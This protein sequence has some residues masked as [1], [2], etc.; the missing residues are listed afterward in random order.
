MPSGARPGL[1]V[2]IIGCKDLFLNTRV[3]RQAESLAQ[4]G[5]RVTIVAFRTPDPASFGDATTLI[6]TGVPPYP[7]FLTT[8]L[9]ATRHVFGNGARL[10][11]AAALTVAAGLS[12]SGLFAARA[13]GRLNGSRFD[14]VQAH[15]DKALIAAAMLRDHCQA[16]LVFD[17]V[18]IPFDDELIPV[19]VSVRALRL[20]EIEQEMRIAKQ[21]DGWITVNDALADAAAERFGI[22]RPA[23]VRNCQ[24]TRYFG[25]DGRLRNDLG[26]GRGARILLHLNTLRREEGVLTAIDALTHLPEEVHLV[27]LGPIPKR[28]FRREMLRHAVERGVSGR[29]HIAPLQPPHAVAEYI[30]GADIGVIARQSGLQNLRFSLPNRVFQMIAARLPVI[31]TPLPEIAKLVRG[32]GVGTLFAEGD[33]A[34]LAAAVR[35]TMQPSVM[36]GL[37]AALDRAAGQ[38]SWKHESSRYVGLIEALGGFRATQ[39]QIGYP[40]IRRDAEIGYAAGQGH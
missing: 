16:K 1:S 15:F 23:V 22:E 3:V 8:R 12:R 33:A 32:W 30:A 11:Q 39:P 40:A 19:P 29:F 9:W 4:N 37:R 26:L 36:T 2:C 38:L 28:G 10:R 25:S 27:G 5:H 35:A 18:E 21:A 17:A 34:G 14:V 6:D 31:A 20:A 13:M 24:D 7:A